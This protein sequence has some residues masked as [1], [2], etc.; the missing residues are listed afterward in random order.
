MVRHD[1]TCR[2]RPALNTHVTVAGAF[3]R[4]A[5]V[6]VVGIQD[7]AVCLCHVVRQAATANN[8]RSTIQHQHH[9][10]VSVDIHAKCNRGTNGRV[11]SSHGTDLV[12]C[13][14]NM[15]A[16]S[17]MLQCLPSTISMASR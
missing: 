14:A 8:T 6:R 5:V 3:L 7:A 12:V 16:A 13:A 2:P 10:F 4:N 9:S 1:Y 17:N 15:V 11:A